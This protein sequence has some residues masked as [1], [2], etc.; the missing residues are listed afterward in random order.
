MQLFYALGEERANPRA[1]VRAVARLRHTEVPAGP[2]LQRSGQQRAGNADHQAAKPER[3]VPDDSCGR[4]KR[5]R[6]GRR[7]GQRDRLGSVGN[8]GGQ[9]LGDGREIEGG[10]VLCAWL[11]VL[12]G[13][14]K[15]SRNR[16]RKQTGL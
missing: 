8:G 1:L 2:L 9:D 14:C 3:I 16:G 4:P 6:I 15:K 13:P 12:V 7:W 5:G 11:Q 10:V